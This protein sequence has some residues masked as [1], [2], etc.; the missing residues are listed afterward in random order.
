M[1]YSC[2]INYSMELENLALLFWN[3][4][5][6]RNLLDLNTGEI[7]HLDIVKAEIEAFQSLAT[8]TM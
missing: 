4:A 8:S 5:F 2:A 3:K 7:Y 6:P 1:H